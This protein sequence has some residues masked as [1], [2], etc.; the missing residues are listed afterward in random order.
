M[1]DEVSLGSSGWTETTTS[2]VQFSSG[3]DIWTRYLSFLI[4]N[5][6]FV[7]TNLGG[8]KSDWIFLSHPNFIL[9]EA[10]PVLRD[11]IKLHQRVFPTKFSFYKSFKIPRFQETRLFLCSLVGWLYHEGQ[12][13]I[14]IT[15]LELGKL[16]K[17]SF[18]LRILPK[19]GGGWFFVFRWPLCFTRNIQKCYETCFTNLGIFPKKWIDWP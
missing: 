15:S 13:T 16:S 10:P 3:F 18:F 11:N 6:L 17:N 14:N 9:F 4:D 5:G 1:Y 2:S 7:S 12:F 19:M 8:L